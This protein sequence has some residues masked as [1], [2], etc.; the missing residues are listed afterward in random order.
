[1]NLLGDVPEEHKQLAEKLV[2]TELEMDGLT[3][4][5]VPY[6]AQSYFC[7][8]HDWFN[9]DMEEEGFRLIKKAFSVCPQY[10]NKYLRAHGKENPDFIKIWDELCPYIA[11]MILSNARSK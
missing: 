6:V 9:I 1:M 8:A 4:I 11:G 3:D 10:H 2:K 7:L 5:S